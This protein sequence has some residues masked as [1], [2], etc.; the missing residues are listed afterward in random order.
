M[1]V[2]NP[3]IP[4]TN[5]GSRFYKQLVEEG[6]IPRNG[7]LYTVMAKD[8]AQPDE[9]WFEIGKIDTTNEPFTQSLWGDERLYF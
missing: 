1:F 8:T 7:L 4:P 3:T 5:G 9:E 6:A 2:S